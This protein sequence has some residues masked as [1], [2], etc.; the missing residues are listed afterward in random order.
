MSSANFQPSK[1]YNIILADPPWSYNNSGFDYAAAKQYSTM[2]LQDICT[3]PIA[4]LADKD[5]CLFL[6]A[7]SPLLPEAMDVI[8]S[9]GFEYKTVAFCWSKIESGGAWVSNMGRWTMG[10]VELC[11]LATKGMPHRIIP[12]SNN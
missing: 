10:N 9:W 3:L 12:N 6:W 1:K 4:G 5:C 8:K 2:P 11:L 7:V